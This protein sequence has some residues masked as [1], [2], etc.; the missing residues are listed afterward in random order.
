MT[1]AIVSCHSHDGAHSLEFNE[2]T[3]RYKLDGLAVPGVTT[4]IKA[5][6]PEGEGLINWRARHAAQHVSDWWQSLE[7]Y[8]DVEEVKATITRSLSAHRAALDSAGD[9]GSAVHDYIERYEGKGRGAA[10]K[11]LASLVDS[12]LDRSGG[13]ATVKKSLLAYSDY[14][15]SGGKFKLVCSETPVASVHHAYA[16]KF[17]RLSLVKGKLVLSDFKTS[18]GIYFAHLV[19]LGAYSVAIKEWMGKS[20]EVFEILRFGKDGVFEPLTITSASD[21]LELEE[22]AIRCRK[23][24]AALKKYGN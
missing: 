3:H 8:P 22:Q 9:I 20:V 1:S 5:T 17:D 13:L 21:I 16:G 14:R 10:E 24:L 7:G 11:F 12:R 18:K 19:Q 15:N 6:L 23:T 2:T 4:L